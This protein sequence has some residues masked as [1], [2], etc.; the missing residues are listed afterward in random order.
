MSERAEARRLEGAEIAGWRAMCAAAPAE[1]RA[2]YGLAVHEVGDATAFVL[3]A[4]PSPMFNR[5][6]GLG[7]TRP[8][9]DEDLDRIVAI[10]A[11]AKMPA[12]YVQVAP[13][14]EPGL[15]DRLRARGFAARPRW[16]KVS[17]GTSAPAAAPT[18]LRIEEVHADRA[19]DY[20][21]TATA[22]Y[23]TPPWFTPWLS[24]LPGHPGFRC[25]VAYDGDAAVSCAL[26]HLA[27]DIA[28]CG[29]AATHP[30]ARRRG[31]QNALFERRVRDA[32][33]AGAREIVTETGEDTP[34]ARNPSLHNMFRAGFV[35]AY[36]KENWMPAGGLTPATPA[37]P[38][39][40]A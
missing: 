34:K 24:A 18:D 11:A 36:R 19:A 22:G 5:V 32:I 3:A 15:E 10:Y 13:G 26:F 39:A 7:L 4:A 12:Y 38:P 1:F 14:A 20:A 35:E 9:T 31:G 40:A 25:Y 30:A 28:W 21:G 17:R 29:V 27:G 37:A 33:A 16:V 23:P 8:A 6:V 2:Q